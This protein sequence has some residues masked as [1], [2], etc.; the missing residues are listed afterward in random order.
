MKQ[1]AI[2]SYL[3]WLAVQRPGSGGFFRYRPTW[4]RAGLGTGTLHRTL[5][6]KALE[7][8]RVG[9]NER[10]RQKMKAGSLPEQVL[11]FSWFGRGVYPD[12]QRFRAFQVARQVFLRYSRARSM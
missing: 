1:A 3:Q 5:T 7:T 10:G 9:R 8:C 12:C 2:L 4:L 6:R 11:T